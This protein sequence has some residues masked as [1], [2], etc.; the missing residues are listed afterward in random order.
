MIKVQ[1]ECEGEWTVYDEET[2]KSATI[3]RF[4]DRFLGEIINYYRVDGSEGTIESM[5]E[6]F[7]T[8]KGVATRYLKG[9]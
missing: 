7:Q 3:V 8:A 5:I 9:V 1:K 6:H 4:E 2:M